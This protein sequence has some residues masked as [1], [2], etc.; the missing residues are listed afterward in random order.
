MINQSYSI[1]VH[2][3]GESNPS[4]SVNLS[5]AYRRAQKALMAS[6]AT[7]V[8][9]VSGYDELYLELL[10]NDMNAATSREFVE[11]VLG[12]LSRDEREVAIQ[13]LSA[14]YLNDGSIQRTADQLFIHKNTLQYKLRRI[15]ETTGMDPRNSRYIPI[16]TLA[17]AFS[18]R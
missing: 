18:K 12:K 6:Q 1:E 13:W 17:I 4:T 7:H 2:S 14:L 11:K 3:G 5:K 10:I 15:K 8:S 16:F 9:T